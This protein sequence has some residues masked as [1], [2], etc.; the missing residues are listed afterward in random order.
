MAQ[1]AV[2]EPV[3]D[4]QEADEAS[5]LKKASLASSA[6]NCRHHL[7]RSRSLDPSVLQDLFNSQFHP[8]PPQLAATPAMFKRYRS[9]RHK[10][11]SRILDEQL[12]CDQ[13]PLAESTISSIIARQTDQVLPAIFRSTSSHSGS[14]SSADCP[15]QTHPQKA[16]VQFADARHAGVHGCMDT[17]RSSELRD[18][19]GLP[20]HEGRLD[21][22]NSKERLARFWE[23]LDEEDDWATALPE[24]HQPVPRPRKLQKHRSD[25]LRIPQRQRLSVHNSSCDAEKKIQST[26]SMRVLRPLGEYNLP[27]GVE[28]IG[29][30]I[31]Y[32]YEYHPPAATRSK[33][34]LRP[35][36]PLS[37]VRESF[38]TLGAKM[39]CGH[40]KWRDEAIRELRLDKNLPEFGEMY[41]SDA[42]GD[43]LSA[44]A[45]PNIPVMSTHMFTIPSEKPSES[46]D[47]LDIRFREMLARES[48]G[49][50]PDTTLRLVSPRHR[51]SFRSVRGQSD[52]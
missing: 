12:R 47:V 41:E 25:A 39:G 33:A 46:F 24:I 52:L 10:K 6:S 28:Q 36:A 44:L 29:H 19:N 27:E 49:E 45:Y 30:G 43:V 38:Y 35:A 34:S 5:S 3:C 32:T 2:E 20:T 15:P 1:I 17:K 21:E 51:L 9:Q 22:V 11:H 16:Q 31:G 23:M 42:P 7:R 26:P 40:G 4:V 37:T 18:K 8:E 13:P 48:K 14:P 50:D